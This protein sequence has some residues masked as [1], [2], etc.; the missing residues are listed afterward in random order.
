[1]EKAKILIVE[2]EVIIAMEIKNRLQ[3]LGYEVTSIVNTGEDAIK[4]AEEDKPDLILMDI[5]IKGEM[6]GIDTA[7]IIR[8]KFGIPVVFSTAYLDQERIERAKITMPFGYLLKP[9]QE[10]DLKVTIE[11]A[12]YVVKV[13]GKRR[14]IEESLK[15]SNHRLL[16]FFNQKLIGVSIT[17]VEKGFVEGNDRFCE[18]LGYKK[19]ELNKL[20][21]DKLTYPDDL[22]AEVELFN[23]MLSNKIDKYELEKR[24]IRKTGKI[25]Y[26]KIFIS[27]D[28]RP[29]KSVKNVI[30]LA[31]DITERK[32]VEEK[33]NESE[34][35][36][37]SIV[38]DIPVLL[39]QFLPGGEIVFVNRA[40]CDYFQKTFDELVGQT[41]LTLILEEDRETVWNA[42]ST[43]DKEKPII[44][45]EH[46][47][48]LPDGNTAWHRWT[49]RGLFNDEGEILSYQSIGEDYT[50][51]KETE[52]NLHENMKNLA[53]ANRALQAIRQFIKIRNDSENEIDL[54]RN[55]CKVLMDDCKYVLT[56]I[57]YKEKDVSKKVV[58]VAKAGFE[59]GYLDIIDITW[60]DKKR[61]RAFTPPTQLP[62]HFTQLLLNEV[63]IF[64]H[65][66]SKIPL[67]IIS[68]SP[69][70]LVL[71]CSNHS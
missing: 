30:I 17:S 60:S 57:G 7:E 28:R 11:M 35:R 10:R 15:E 70:S 51:R 4:K 53:Y 13:D 68:I 67:Y 2:D 42:I 56:W 8:N 29:D 32:K 39:C 46:K 71:S 44:S 55:V 36:Y 41:F 19:E 64:F 37:R 65:C 16:S 50:D 25:V 9:I 62:L 58:P 40:Y 12:L 43:L 14:Q 1:M 5:R 27:C 66:Q 54:L 23:K 24:F 26:T 18:I 33:L 31:E 47:V 49:N 6:D 22:R 61:G 20:T 69:A 63:K 48:I 21:W 34:A 38:E 3:N 45:H 52:I 59:N